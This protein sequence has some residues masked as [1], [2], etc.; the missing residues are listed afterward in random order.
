VWWLPNFFNATQDVAANKHLTGCWE[1]KGN[2]NMVAI[3]ST[4]PACGQEE[5]VVKSLARSG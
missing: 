5:A 4:R 1:E 3:C 2:T